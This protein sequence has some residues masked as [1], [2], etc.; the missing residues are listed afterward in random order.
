MRL[1]W[2]SSITTLWLWFQR[3]EVRLI[4]RS[5]SCKYS[6]R[7]SAPICRPT[8]HTR[9][10]AKCR[11]LSN[12]LLS[13]CHCH[14][15]CHLHSPFF[16]LAVHINKES[17]CEALRSIKHSGYIITTISIFSTH[18]IL[19]F[20]SLDT[21]KMNDAYLQRS[22]LHRTYALCRTPRPPSGS[23]TAS[24]RIT[25]CGITLGQRP[26]ILRYCLCWHLC[27][28]R[29]YFVFNHHQSLF[30]NR[31]L[32]SFKYNRC[33]PSKFWNL[34]A[35]PTNT[36]KKNCISWSSIR[37]SACLR[38]WASRTKALVTASSQQHIKSERP[39]LMNDPRS[40]LGRQRPTGQHW[41]MVFRMILFQTLQIC[42]LLF[43]GLCP[44]AS[45]SQLSTQFLTEVSHHTL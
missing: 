29:L 21:A 19:T 43:Q 15:R 39:S 22:C 32:K 14:F 8:T 42:A 5:L 12:S 28:Q 37:C 1:D 11:S 38:A 2:R 35:Y 34:C 24:M 27:Y 36:Y 30:I 10:K 16:E 44:S 18:H 25:E 41:Y 13:H 45:C 31:I 9:T 17:I 20:I 33:H 23:L 26:L 6:G 3:P 4:E 40:Q 7:F